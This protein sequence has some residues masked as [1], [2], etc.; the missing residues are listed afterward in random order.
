VIK[1]RIIQF[2]ALTSGVHTVSIDDFRLPGLAHYP[3]KS[4]KF[5]VR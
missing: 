5:D 1:V 2:G 3:E 4:R